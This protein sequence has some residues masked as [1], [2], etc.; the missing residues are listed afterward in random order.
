M[1][2]S[3][4]NL[5]PNLTWAIYASH[6]TPLKSKFLLAKDFNQVSAGFEFSTLA[7]GRDPGFQNQLFQP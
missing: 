6:S 4:W 1:T 3:I 2:A 7:K 5:A